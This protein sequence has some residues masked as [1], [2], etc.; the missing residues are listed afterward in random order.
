[1]VP[2]VREEALCGLLADHVCV[3]LKVV[4]ILRRLDML[5]AMC[6]AGNQI[7]KLSRVILD[8]TTLAQLSSRC[9]SLE[10]LELNGCSVV[11]KE[12]RSNS[13]RCLTMINC[14]FSIGSGV[15]APNLLSLRC[16]RPFQQVPQFWNMEFLAT[17]IISL[18]D[19]C[20]PSDSWWTW[21]EDDKDEPY[22]NDNIAVHSGAEDLDD[23][24]G[25][26]GAVDEV[27]GCTVCYEEIA[28]K[29]NG[30]CGGKFGGDGLL[31]SLSNVRTLELSAHSG[32]ANKIRVG[33]NPEASSFTC[34]N[35][36]KVEIT[37][38]KNDDML[39]ILAKLF[40]VNGIAHEKIF[41]R[42]TTCTCD[43]KRNAGSK[44]KRKAQ[45]E[46][47]KRPEKQIKL[48]Y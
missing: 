10:E 2:V 16:I 12:I 26:S 24:R 22:L 3:G 18:D 32:E 9:T 30:A 36:K 35:L 21:T 14:K 29:Y 25:S 37:C 19:S 13:L 34:T 23:N 28:D 5:L 39:S 46:S 40:H 43:A 27:D 11:G 6:R 7:L 41:V 1:M 47:E 31:C 44:A 45:T 8:D 48:G 4:Y 17:A 38:C 20:M 42:R 15:H 33:F